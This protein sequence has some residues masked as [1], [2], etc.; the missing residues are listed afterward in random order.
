M[1]VCVA[2][3]FNVIHKGHTQLLE[4]AFEV[5]EVVFIGLTS[6]E[7]AASLRDV[8]VQ[9]YDVRERHLV[10]EAQRLSGGKRFHIVRISD[11]H[12]PAATGNYDAIIV[13]KQ[14]ESIAADINEVRKRKGLKGLEIIVIDMVLADD[15]RPVSS[16]RVL[17]GEVAVDGKLR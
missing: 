12:G 3:T 2:G 8:S 10:E 14:T 9:S 17:R 5:G 16:T 15:R 4:R 7:M 6:D 11:E 13:S 1:K